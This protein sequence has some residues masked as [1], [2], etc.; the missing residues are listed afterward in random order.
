MNG[1]VPILPGGPGV[2]AQWRNPGTPSNA[3]D[4]GGQGRQKWRLAPEVLANFQ[5]NS[6]G[7]TGTVSFRVKVPDS[8]LRTKVV[9]L[10]QNP[11]SASSFTLQGKGLTLWLR[12]TEFGYQTGKYYPVTNL[13]GTGATPGPIPGSIDP[14]TGLPAADPDLQGFGKEF[15]TSGAAIEGTVTY[16]VINNSGKGQLILQVEYIAEAIR[17]PRHEWA[18]IVSETGIVV[19]DTNVVWE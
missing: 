6:E 7:N 14:A 13:W 8:R 15:V 9:L 4:D 19:L 5:G 17:F 1:N 11:P 18:E 3:T 2:P 10:P 16:A 12:D